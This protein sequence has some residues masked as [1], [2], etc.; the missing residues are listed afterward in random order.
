VIFSTLVVA[1]WPGTSRGDRIEDSWRKN[2]VGLGNITI[3]NLSEAWRKANNDALEFPPFPLPLFNSCSLDGHDVVISPLPQ[4]T[5]LWG[6]L[7][8]QGLPRSKWHNEGKL[9]WVFSR[10]AIY[11]FEKLLDRFNPRLYEAVRAS[12]NFP[13]GFP[14]VEIETDA[15]LM[16]NPDDEKSQQGLKTVKLTDGGVLSNSGMWSLFGLLMKNAPEL[17]KRGVLLIVVEASKMPEYRDNRRSH[18][19]LY[20]AI[21]DRNPIGQ[22]LHRRMYDLLSK[23]YGNRLSV[24]QIDIVPTDKYNVLTTWALDKRSEQDLRDSFDMRW[25][26]ESQCIEE[27]W[28]SIQQTKGEGKLYIPGSLRPPLS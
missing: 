28:R 20:G 13:F 26:E 12:A 9:T 4:E 5:Y 22:N 15:S 24:V 16:F 8:D 18:T 11:G 27:K 21:G 3:A 2:P 17:K 1:L 23:E 19:S 7:Y 14:L 10:N 6:A 25:E